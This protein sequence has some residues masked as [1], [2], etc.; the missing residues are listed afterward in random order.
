MIN[1]KGR[2]CIKMYCIRRQVRKAFYGKRKTND[3]PS[4]SYLPR[5]VK[6]TRT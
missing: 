4:V 6:K 5:K 2:E 1:K 3:A